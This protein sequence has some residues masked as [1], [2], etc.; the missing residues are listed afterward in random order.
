MSIE[1]VLPSDWSAVS[2]IYAQGM[3]TRNA[4]FE[5]E[6]PTWEHRDA[7]HLADCRFVAR[8]DTGVLGWVACAH[9]N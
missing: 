3:A 9:L 8:D 2:V 7:T 6:L 1:R 5:T 4:T